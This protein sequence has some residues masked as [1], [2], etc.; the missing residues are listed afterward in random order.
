[1]ALMA[2]LLLPLTTAFRCQEHAQTTDWRATLKTIWKSICKIDTSLN[3]TLD[4]S[5]EARSGSASRS[6]AT[7]VFPVLWL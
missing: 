1:R 3:A 5:W 4:L 6:A 2:L 7:E